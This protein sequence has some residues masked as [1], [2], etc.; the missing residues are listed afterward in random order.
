MIDK[1]YIEWMHRAIDGDL[2][3]KDTEELM[4][5]LQ[6]NTEAQQLFEQLR[7]TVDILDNT[8]DIEPPANLKHRIM[9]SIDFSRYATTRQKSGFI[10]GLIEWLYR[11]QA[12][13]IYAFAAG[14]LLGLFVLTPF[15]F[16]HPQPDAADLV[17]TIGV[18]PDIRFQTIQELPVRI[19]DINGKI[20]IK[21][22]QQ[23]IKTAVN[24]KSNNTA[25]LTIEFDPAFLQWS[26]LLPG[27]TETV[28]MD[29]NVGN[30]TLQI[31]DNTNISL[32]FR[33]LQPHA[34]LTLHFSHNT[35]SV[36]KKT[37]ALP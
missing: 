17:G 20:T 23:L 2:A 13:L 26:Q 9:N 24:I 32:F 18:Y 33:Q 22:Y 34:Q 16:K 3:S 21:K 36:L 35:T 31:S 11:P 7:Q 37:I 14:L 8:K 6:N 19:P 27:T 29:Y 10:E 30:I 15:I 4:V 28:K 12:K 25:H 5:Y 1:K